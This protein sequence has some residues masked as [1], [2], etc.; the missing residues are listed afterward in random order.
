MVII[1]AFSGVGTKKPTRTVLTATLMIMMTTTPTVIVTWEE[2]RGDPYEKA[3]PTA[4]DQ[5]IGTIEE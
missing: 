1:T 5:M 3:L 2:S 4:G